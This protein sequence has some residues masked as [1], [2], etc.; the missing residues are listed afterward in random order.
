MKYEL[1]PSFINLLIVILIVSACNTQNKKEPP[2]EKPT[3]EI[4]FI[5]P[6][7]DLIPGEVNLDESCF[8]EIK[9]LAGKQITT[10]EIMKIKETEILVCDSMLIMKNLSSGNMLKAFSLPDFKLIKSF[11]KAGRGP[12]ELQSPKL[13]K[14]EEDECLCYIYQQANNNL[15][16]LDFNLELLEVDFELPKSTTK[17]A[18]ND[19]QLYSL[20]ASNFVYVESIPRGKGLFS[21][22]IE[23]DSV[24]HKMVHNL[25]FS[26]S[27][28][29]WASYIGDFAANQKKGRMVFAYKYFK[30]LTFTDLEGKNLRTLI[31]DSN[32][33]KRGD[34]VSVMGP[35]NITHYWGISAQKEHVYLL[36]SGRSPIDVNREWAKK[37]Y[38]IFVEQYDW[39]G[40][41]VKKYKLDNWGYFTVDEERGKIYMASV[42]DAEPFFVFDLVE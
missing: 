30:R 36:Y 13:V 9:E 10:N 32:E 21:Y 27:H 15:Y 3:D 14:A 29:S 41:P 42:N 7:P 4:V 17:R 20:S 16:K 28:K 12:G 38:Y 26:D 37:S 23:D 18:F 39:N 19:K 31:F 40:N 22:K 25:S 8:G 24:Y 5:E 34:A 1:H 35:E 6:F 2:P 11:G 33:A